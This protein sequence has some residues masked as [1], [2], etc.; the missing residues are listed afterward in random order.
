MSNPKEPTQHKV[1]ELGQP[2]DVTMSALQKSIRAGLEREACYW[3]LLLYR[4]S[5]GLAW[6]RVLTCAAE[7]IG[8]ANPAV[9]AQVAAFHQASLAAFS[10]KSSHFLVLSV[11][12]LAR[13]PKS[14]EC[15]DL[16]T[17]LL[18]ELREGVKYPIREE[19]LDGHTEIGRRRGATWKSWYDFRHR[20]CKIPVSKYLLEL[21]RHRPEWKPDEID[22]SSSSEPG[23]SPV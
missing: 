21:F 6:R 10:A 13:S 19:F 18:E 12:L 3:G 2:L 7:D 16:Q 23:G 1:T 8:A 5:P 9:V 14:T 22:D 4:L 17:L 20:V 15:E 11:L